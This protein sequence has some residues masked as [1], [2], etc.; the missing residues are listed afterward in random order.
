MWERQ[1]NE[2][3]RTADGQEQNVEKGK[4]MKPEPE[5]IREMRN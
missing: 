4:W 3:E 5:E 1:K 2:K